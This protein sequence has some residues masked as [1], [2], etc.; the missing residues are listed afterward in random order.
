MK[1]LAYL[2]GLLFILSMSSCNQSRLDIDVSQVQVPPIEIKRLEKDLFEINPQEI[3]A[4]TPD[5][6]KKYG[7]FYPLF[8]TRIVNDGGIKDSSYI[9]NL[10]Q[11]LLDANMRE[12]YNDCIKK[13]PELD[14][15]SA[16]LTDAFKHYKHYFPEKIIPRVV[17]YMSGFNYSIVSDDSTLG[18]GIEMYLGPNSQFYKMI[19][20]PKYK[21]VTMD[22]EYILPDCIRGWLMNE[23]EYNQ[24]QNDFLSQIV[25]YGKIMYLLDAMLPE[26]EDSLKTG[27]SGKQ[28]KWCKKNENE[29]WS[30]LVSQKMLYSTD[31]TE[32]IKYTHEGPFTSAFSKESPARTGHWIGWQIVKSYMNN[33]SEI[34]LQQLVNETDAQKILAQSKYKP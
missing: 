1:R 24:Q 17:T 28:L 18:I 29:M 21:T 27:F 12:A 6:V 15:L 7:S 31:N 30:Y 22:K 25:H 34:T 33:H 4:K 26:V 32:I 11:F 3:A 9:Y 5:L 16:P 13:Y 2:Y 8:I 19:Q 10:K 23:F 14:F 20:F